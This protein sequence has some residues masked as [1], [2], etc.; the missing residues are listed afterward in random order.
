MA[1]AVFGEASASRFVASAAFG[2]KL[3]DSRSVKCF[4]YIQSGS[5]RWGESAL[6]T[7][8]CEMRG[9]CPDH[10]Q[11]MV[12]SCSNRPFFGG[13]M[14]GILRSNLKLA[15]FSEVWR[16][17]CVVSSWT[18]TDGVFGVVRAMDLSHFYDFGCTHECMIDGRHN[19]W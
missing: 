17:S 10:I 8:W 6:P 18:F 3:G 9:L 12:G 14:S 16:N 15:F 7:G 5:P 11:I 2:G 13:S 4:F 19:I 1:G